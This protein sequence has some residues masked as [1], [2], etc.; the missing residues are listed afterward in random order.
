MKRREKKYYQK[1]SDRE[2][3]IKQHL[4]EN[5]LFY[6]FEGR[7]IDRPKHFKV[8]NFSNINFL[9]CECRNNFLSPVRYSQYICMAF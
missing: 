6:Y 5:S 9:M 3:L 4:A 1:Y 2:G 7:E 8:S